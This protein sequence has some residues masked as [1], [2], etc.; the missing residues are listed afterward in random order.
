MDMRRRGQ[1]LFL[2]LALLAGA[3]VASGQTIAKTVGYVDSLVPLKGR[4]YFEVPVDRPGA[5]YRVSVPYF[6]WIEGRGKGRLLP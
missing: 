5:S 6:D 1:A 2:V 3:G 4:A